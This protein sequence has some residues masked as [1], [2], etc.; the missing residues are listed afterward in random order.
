MRLKPL[1][2]LWSGPRSPMA[3]G[4]RESDAGSGRVL[5]V[6]H[7]SMI[8]L[9][10]RPGRRQAESRPAR[11]PP[12]KGPFRISERWTRGIMEGD[13]ASPPWAIEAL[14]PRSEAIRR[15]DND[16]AGAATADAL[17]SRLTTPCATPAAQ[18]LRAARPR[19]RAPRPP[20]LCRRRQSRHS[21]PVSGPRLEVVATLIRTRRLDTAGL[22]RARRLGIAGAPRT[23]RIQGATSERARRAGLGATTSQS[24]VRGRGAYGDPTTSAGSRA[25]KGGSRPRA[26]RKACS[27]G[28][29]TPT[30]AAVR[31]LPD[32]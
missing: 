16:A 14:R 12:A 24:A 11:V 21:R 2:A 20:P 27:R 4:G 31:I 8:A 1:P 28:T 13:P 29:H 26:H 18:R 19:A 6:R 10:R 15:R 23:F 25:G 30:V 32:L 17:L 7:G 5:G 9:D 3:D 22:L